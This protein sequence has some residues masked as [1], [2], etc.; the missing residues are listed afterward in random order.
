MLLVCADGY[1]VPFTPSLL[2]QH[3]VR[4][5][6]ASRD[7]ALPADAEAPWLPYQHGAEIQRFDREAYFA[8]SRPPEGA[9]DSVRA[10]FAIYR[11]H[12]AKCHRTR[13]ARAAPAAR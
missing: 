11:N 12:C 4:G 2:S 13:G 9:D 8:P 10:G 1:R 3:R 5:M 7:T 6:L